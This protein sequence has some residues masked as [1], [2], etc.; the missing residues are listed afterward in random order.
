MRLHTSFSG[1]FDYR[2][3]DYTLVFR[4]S[5]KL[6]LMQCVNIEI[7]DDSIKDEKTETF[8]VQLST[9]SSNVDFINPKFSISIKMGKLEL[10]L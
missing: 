7:Y 2:A 5:H 1:N 3:V 6:K 8:T 10:F 4:P 9:N